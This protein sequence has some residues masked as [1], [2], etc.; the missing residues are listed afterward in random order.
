MAAQA[1]PQKKPAVNP[2]IAKGRA[3]GSRFG[4]VIYK[5]KGHVVRV[6]GCECG[7]AFLDLS[8]KSEA[9]RRYAYAPEGS[10]HPGALLTVQGPQAQFPAQSLEIVPCQERFRHEDS[11]ATQFHRRAMGDRTTF[12]GCQ[13]IEEDLLKQDLIRH[14]PPKEEIMGWREPADKGELRGSHDA[15]DDADSLESSKFAQY[16]QQAPEEEEPDDDDEEEESDEDKA[17]A[18]RHKEAWVT[19]VHN[20][21]KELKLTYR[22]SSAFKLV[23]PKTGTGLTHKEAAKKLR[24]KPH[25]LKDRLEGIKKKVEDLF[26][27][28]TKKSDE[29]PNLWK[30]PD[31]QVDGFYVRSHAKRV[32]PL[33]RVNPKT[34]HKALMQPRKAK[35]KLVKTPQAGI[36]EARRKYSL[37]VYSPAHNGSWCSWVPVIEGKYSRGSGG[38]DPAMVKVRLAN[39]RPNIRPIKPIELELDNE[40]FRPGLTLDLGFLEADL[41]ALPVASA[42]GLGRS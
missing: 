24:I 26:P 29:I 2:C 17:I 21:S 30:A 12:R 19:L 18:P 38:F 22:Q 35:D 7:Q 1:P 16:L 14:R 15:W 41:A 31:R 10:A 42:G 23:Y 34:G 25:S 13:S 5:I 40:Q 11:T 3:G 8:R 28:T 27:G 33:Y 37:L 9:S 20:R 4:G 32:A 39:I 6:N 36:S